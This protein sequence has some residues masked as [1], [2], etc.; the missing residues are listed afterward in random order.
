[1]GKIKRKQ[2]FVDRQVQS[3]LLLRSLGY[4]CLCLF[5]LAASVLCWRVYVGPAQPFLAHL[6][7][8]WTQF[9]PAAGASFLLLPI[10]LMDVL[11]VSNRLC[12]PMVRIRGG[13]RRL[14][15]GESVEL[16]KCREG[17]FWQEFAEEYNAVVATVEHLRA[18]VGAR[19]TP[20]AVDPLESNE[21]EMADEVAGAT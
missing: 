11:R 16:M 3:A 6:R 19:R 7:A 15:A 1:M 8:M 13:M 12:G 10:V 2:L 5:M 21:R 4:W 9:G 14:A 17:D 20:N 18:Q